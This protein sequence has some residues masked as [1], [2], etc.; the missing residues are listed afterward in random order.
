MVK[1]ARKSRK[2]TRKSSKKGDEFDGFMYQMLHK[3]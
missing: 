3:K 1:K 2:G